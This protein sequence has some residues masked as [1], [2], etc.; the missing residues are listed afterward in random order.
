MPS[1]TNKRIAIASLAFSASAFVT[2]ALNEGYSPTAYIPVKGDVPTIGFGTTQNVH[3]GERTTPIQAMQ[4]TLKDVNKYEKQVK[5]CVHVPLTQGEYDAYV[6][7][8]YN[9][10]PYAFC[11]STL[12]N[13]LNQKDYDGAC[14]Q[15]L[16]WDMFHGRV[17]PGLAARRW[18]EYRRCV[19][20]PNVLP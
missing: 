2:L 14:R 19:G 13:L 3:M 1:P 16:R 10:G 6:D 17:L 7:F 18:E 8:T 11:H 20:D 9:V 5:E 15:L 12:V 4:T